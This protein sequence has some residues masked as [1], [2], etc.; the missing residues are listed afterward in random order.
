MA[1]NTSDMVIFANSLIGERKEIIYRR[2]SQYLPNR[3]HSAFREFLTEF[4]EQVTLEIIGGAYT[5][6]DEFEIIH[7]A[8]EDQFWDWVAHEYNNPFEWDNYPTP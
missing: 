6:K 4:S 8:I 7:G 3:L 5:K 1:V 2:V